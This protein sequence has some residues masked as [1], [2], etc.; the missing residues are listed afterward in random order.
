M[1]GALIIIILQRRFYQPQARE[2]KYEFYSVKM[3][4]WLPFLP[5]TVCPEKF[6]SCPKSASL[7]SL[8]E[9]TMTEARIRIWLAKEGEGFNHFAT[10]LGS[11]HVLA[12]G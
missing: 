11:S 9:S 6:C 1:L 3:S 4:L 8:L 5:C 7:V 2:I 10:F 12:F